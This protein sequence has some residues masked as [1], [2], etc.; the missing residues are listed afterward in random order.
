MTVS[1]VHLLTVQCAVRCVYTPWDIQTDYFIYASSPS[2]PHRVARCCV[3]SVRVAFS[4][5][6]VLNT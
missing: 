2:C 1:N 4:V 3:M 5:R 6:Y